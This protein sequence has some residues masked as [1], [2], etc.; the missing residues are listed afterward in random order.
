MGISEVCGC[1]LLRQK[2]SQK[3]LQG[4]VSHKLA[5]YLPYFNQFKLNE[6]WPYY[7]KYVNQIILNHTTL[8]SVALQIFEAFAQILLLVNLS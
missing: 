6:L 3:L 1:H 4:S 2:S 8:E 7:Q 5:A